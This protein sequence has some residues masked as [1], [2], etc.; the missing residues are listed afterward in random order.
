MLRRKVFET[1]CGVVEHR[2]SLFELCCKMLHA[3]KQMGRRFVALDR[4]RDISSLLLIGLYASD[5]TV[6][7]LDFVVDFRNG[8]S[9]SQHIQAGRCDR[10]ASLAE[11]HRSFNTLR[12]QW[13]LVQPTSMSSRLVAFLPE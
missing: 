4:C 3:L 8:N 12:N 5:L 10:C 1:F 6:H 7:E 2:P 9:V 13:N 11:G